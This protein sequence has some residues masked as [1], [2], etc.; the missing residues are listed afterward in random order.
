MR[1]TG[2]GGQVR[3]VRQRH[4]MDSGAHV[5]EKTQPVACYTQGGQQIL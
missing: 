3:E 1:Q 5:V 4:P 2:F